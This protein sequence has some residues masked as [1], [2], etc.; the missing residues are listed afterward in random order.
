MVGKQ[1]SPLIDFLK[2]TDDCSVTS[3]QETAFELYSASFFVDNADARFTLLMM[4]IET[5]IDQKQRS[6]A[7]MDHVRGLIERTRDSSL[8][9]AEV[10]SMIG[11]LEWLFLE[12]IGQ[13]G[14]RLVQSLTSKKY[15]GKPAVS[16]FTDCYEIRSALVHGGTP[17]PSRQEVDSRAATLEI[18]V[19]DLLASS[20][21]CG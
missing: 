13:A 7:A 17:R 20:I 21:K 3:R 5:L 18:L 6:E 11:A 1:G 9:E 15:N 12:S 19:G 16:F 10:Q 8:P 2:S 14:R 4:A